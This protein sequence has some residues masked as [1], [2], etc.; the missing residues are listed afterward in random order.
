VVPVTDRVGDAVP[1]PERVEVNEEVGT[2][3][4]AGVESA[5]GLAV[6]VADLEVV[7][8]PVD[9]EVGMDAVDVA[10]AVEVI[11]GDPE[12]VG[13]APTLRDPVGEAVPVPEMLAVYEEV[14]VTVGDWVS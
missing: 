2:G 10:E 5:V 6:T 14:M 11:E 4:E 9:E 8:D 13:L 12:E 7:P 3:V 1:V